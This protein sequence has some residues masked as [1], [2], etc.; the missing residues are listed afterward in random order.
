[1]IFSVQNSNLMYSVE[2]SHDLVQIQV[3]ETVSGV[4]SGTNGHPNLSLAHGGSDAKGFQRTSYDTSSHDR[5][6]T[7]RN[8]N[9]G[10]SFWSCGNELT[11]DSWLKTCSSTSRRLPFSLGGGGISRKP[12]HNRWRWVFL[13]NNDASGSTTTTSNGTS[14]SSAFYREP[15]E[16]FC[17]STALWL[18]VFVNNCCLVL[19]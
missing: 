15:T 2:F 10:G 1:M 8:A 12:H 3:R 18:N 13:R 11:R 4:F 9:D 17:C 19:N 7:W 6:P 16:L 5:E 14:S